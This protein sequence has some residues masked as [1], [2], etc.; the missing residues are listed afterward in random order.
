MTDFDAD[1][2]VAPPFRKVKQRKFWTSDR[3]IGYSGAG[4]ALMA[5]FFPWYVFLNSARFGI[6]ATMSLIT[7]NFSGWS[8]RDTFSTT[9]TAITNDGLTVHDLS[10]H[11]PLL[12]G[13]V[14]GLDEKT[15]ALDDIGGAD[16]PFPTQ[17]TKF[18]LLHVSKGKALIED[19]NGVYVVQ[20]GSPLPDQS[21]VAS[22]E[23]R[24]G[25]WVIITDKGDIYGTDG[26]RQQ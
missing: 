16:Q 10:S 8:D 22:V 12:T 24:G 23:E 14:P 13:T 6:D 4:L 1:E 2:I 18:H 25:S 3:V 20:P 9:P 17:V 21:K 26:K 19:D 15:K 7:R 5:A 11:D